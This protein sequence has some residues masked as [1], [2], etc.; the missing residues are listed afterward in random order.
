M[1]A[2]IVMHYINFN[3]LDKTY[4]LLDTFTGLTDEYSTPEEMVKNEN[5]GY[6]KLVG[7]YEKVKHSFRD[8]NVEIIQGT[9]P[10]TL[11]QVKT[12]QICYLSVDMNCVLP[13]IAALDF[14]WDKL[15]PGGVIILD[16]YGYGNNRDQKLAH[17]EW[18]AKKNIK[19]LSLPTAQG[20]IIKSR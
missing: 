20:L 17:D 1:Y 6:Q 11:P 18:A 16:D 4:Y 19:I 5:F 10:E 15:V 9:V 2:R 13:E 3:A 14:F 8:F 7:L 12:N